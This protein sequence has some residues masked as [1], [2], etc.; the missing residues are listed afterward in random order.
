MPEWGSE[1][2]RGIDMEVDDSSSRPGMQ[3]L[4]QLS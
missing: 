4:T 2:E 1:D 3:V